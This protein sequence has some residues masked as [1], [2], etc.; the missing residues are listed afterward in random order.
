M[1]RAP[2]GS[3]REETVVKPRL[4]AWDKLGEEGEGGRCQAL[5]G[6]FQGQQC[7]AR[8]HSEHGQS[9]DWELWRGLKG[10]CGAPMGSLPERREDGRC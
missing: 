2:M 10:R 9:T 5:I 6:S 3:S 1:P 7:N 8:E 4:G